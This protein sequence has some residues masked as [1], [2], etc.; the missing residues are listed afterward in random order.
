M[1]VKVI[2]R[3]Q[4]EEWIRLKYPQAPELLN[5]KLNMNANVVYESG[6]AELLWDCWCKS[7]Q[8][9]ERASYTTTNQQTFMGCECNYP[10]REYQNGFCNHCGGVEYRRV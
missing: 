9:H 8:I 7:A 2:S 1:R 10:N 4:F 3:E 5:R 6:L